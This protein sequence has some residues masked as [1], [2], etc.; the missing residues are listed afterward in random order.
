MSRPNLF[1]YA[2]KELSQN[3]MICWL[4][5]WSEV[6]A[7]DECG[8]AL[9]DLGRAFAEALLGKHNQSLAGNI[10]RVEISRWDQGIDV[11]AR[12]EDESAE[13][14]LLIEDKTDTSDHSGQLKCYRDAVKNGVTNRGN[15]SEHWPIYLKS[16]NQSRADDRRIENET[17]FK[18]FRRE[19]FLTVPESYPGSNPIVTDFRKHLQEL[20]DDFN[21]FNDWKQDDRA[22]WSWGAW[23]GFY[24]RLECELRA[25]HG[26][27][28]W[29]YIPIG[30]FLGFWWSP[31]EEDD[32]TTFYLQL[33]VVPKT[34]G[35][36]KLC[37]KVAAGTEDA[38]KKAAEYYDLIRGAEKAVG[39]GMIEKPQHMRTGETMTV[40]WWKGEWLAFKGD[41]RLDIGETAENMR[42]ARRIVE[43]ARTLAR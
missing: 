19:D 43:A 26:K 8:Q 34:S 39:E 35:K 2:T 20:E 7:D 11:L 15:V 16:G 22:N 27:M 42:Q 17:G 12:I 33:E 4:I 6:Q 18:V 23:E 31:F 37:F 21:G 5:K 25:E 14:V 3:A 29:E 13:R 9:R 41:S 10:K 24:R 28:G 36:Q 38:D 30:D 32:K 1:T 40:G